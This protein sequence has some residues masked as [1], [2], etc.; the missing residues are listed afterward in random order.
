MFCVI[1]VTGHCLLSSAVC[2]TE[3]VVYC[4]IHAWMLAIAEAALYIVWSL[5]Q[6]VDFLLIFINFTDDCE[7]YYI[8]NPY[9]P[10]F[11]IWRCGT[12]QCIIFTDDTA[13]ACLYVCLFTRVAIVDVVLKFAI[14]ISL[15]CG[16]RI[17]TGRLMELILHG[18][19]LD[20]A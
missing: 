10:F 1:I 6:L 20:Y 16:C 4:A 13:L 18:T 5:E 19:V 14:H 8:V 11:R 17:S 3:L 7:T 2:I 15:L 12:S 9:I